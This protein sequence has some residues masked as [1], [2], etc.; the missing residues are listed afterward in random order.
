MFALIGALASVVSA[1]VGIFNIFAGA[2]LEDLVDY[3]DTDE[4]YDYSDY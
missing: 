1:L 4:D 3:D 2:T